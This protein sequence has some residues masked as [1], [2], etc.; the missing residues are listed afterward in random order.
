VRFVYTRFRINQSPKE[1]INVHEMIYRIKKYVCNN[2]VRKIHIFFFYT[3]TNNFKY[4]FYTRMYNVCFHLDLHVCVSNFY[5]QCF[6]DIHMYFTRYS[7]RKRN[8]LFCYFYPAV[9]FVI[10]IYYRILQ[11]GCLKFTRTIK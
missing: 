3:K 5:C 7:F 6:R 8:I 2:D 10:I 1:I 11:N 9:D 4:Q